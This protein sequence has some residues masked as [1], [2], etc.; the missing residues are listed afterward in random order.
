MMTMK[1]KEHSLVMHSVDSAYPTLIQAW[2]KYLLN[3]G[4]GLVAKIMLNS[5]IF[6]VKYAKGISYSPRPITTERS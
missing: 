2:I 4:Y 3:D 5:V 6:L 1:T